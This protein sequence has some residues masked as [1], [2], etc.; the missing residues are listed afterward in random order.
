MPPTERK[1][2]TQ[3]IDWWAAFHEYATKAGVS[4]SEWLGDA[5][6]EK[7]PA[8]VAAKLSDRPSAHRPRSK[9]GS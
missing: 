1:H 9:E 2:I 7:L 4:L 6:K 3:P 8:K 5:G